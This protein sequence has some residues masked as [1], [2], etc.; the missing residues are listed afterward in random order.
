MRI[1]LVRFRE[2]VEEQDYAMLEE[3]QLNAECG[4]QSEVVFGRNEAALQHF[5]SVYRSESGRE[6]LQVE[7]V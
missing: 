3:V 4:I 7:G 6:R 5:H 2:V 1:R